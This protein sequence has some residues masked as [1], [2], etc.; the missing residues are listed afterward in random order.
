MEINNFLR[1]LGHRLWIIPVVPAL[2]IA[3]G[4][5]YL[6]SQPPQYMASATLIS[7]PSAGAGTGNAADVVAQSVSNIEGAITSGP[8]V[9]QISITTEVPGGAVRDGLDGVQVGGANIVEISYTGGDREVASRVV[10]A[11]VDEVLKLRKALGSPN[12]KTIPG[13]E[14]V[15]EISRSSTLTR[16]LISVT[17][18]AVLLAL[19]LVFILETISPS[20]SKK[21]EAAGPTPI[22]S[23][24]HIE[25]SRA[26]SSDA[27]PS[28]VASEQPR[29]W[30]RPGSSSRGS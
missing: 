29:R 5:G 4:L 26:G 22:A 21:P 24:H 2:A 12:L 7:P 14:E 16:G 9:E 10:T 15:D 28:S 18:L 25:D 27:A 3:V 17:G 8:V 1:A 30:V 6:L 20:K 11:A 23:T 19:G 13:S